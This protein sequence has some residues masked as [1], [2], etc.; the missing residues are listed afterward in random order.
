MWAG[1][2]GGGVSAQRVSP[3]DCLA[4]VEV[5]V[6]SQPPKIPGSRM[7]VQL[8]MWSLLMPWVVGDLIASC[9]G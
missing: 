5:N 1:A 9:Q 7:E 2:G 3:F 4:V 6:P 8:S